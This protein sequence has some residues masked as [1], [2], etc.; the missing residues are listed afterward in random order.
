MFPSKELLINEW[1]WGWFNS[2]NDIRI[3]VPNILSPDE[4]KNLTGQDFE[5]QNNDSAPQQ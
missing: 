3:Y 2:A 1:Q 5:Q 4:F